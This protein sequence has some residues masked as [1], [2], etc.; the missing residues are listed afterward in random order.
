MIRQFGG[1]GSRTLKHGQGALVQDLPPRLA[2]VRIDHV[3]DQ[4]MCEAIAARTTCPGLLLTQEATPDGLL[5]G[6]HACPPVC[7]N[8]KSASTES[9]VSRACEGDATGSV[10]EGR[11]VPGSPSPTSASMSWSVS[12]W[13][14]G[15][16]DT[17]V[18]GRSRP[19]LTNRAES[20]GLSS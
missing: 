10:V 17:C 6:L 14:R 5:Q 9:F 2:Q 11:T 7:A 16:N 8:R 1:P 13:L 20:C 18:T 19:R 4:V 3:A 15:C 12:A